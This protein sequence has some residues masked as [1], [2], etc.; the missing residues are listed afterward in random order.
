MKTVF[1]LGAGA[2]RAAGGPL[3][4][5][6]LD[7]AQDLLRFQTPGITK[8]QK[9]FDDVFKAIAELQ[10]VHSKAYLDLNNIEIVFGAIEMG[11]LLKQLGDRDEDSIKALRD[12]LITL[13]YKTLEFSI[14]FPAPNGLLNPPK[15]YD[16]FMS[17]LKRIKEDHPSPDPHCF[18]FITFNYD[19]CLD[20]TLYRYYSSFN[21]CLNPDQYSTDI[22]LLKLHG[23]INWGLSADDRIVPFK[24]NDFHFPFSKGGDGYMNCDLGSRLHEMAVDGK[25]LKGPPVIVP[26]TWNK[27]SYHGQLSNVWSRAAQE[28]STAEN[29]FIIG[30][31]L[32]ETDSFFRY[33]Y[34]LGSESPTRIR[35]F[36]V[37]NK[38]DSGQ[39]EGRFRQLIGR[40]IETRF[41]YIGKTFEE[42]IGQIKDILMNP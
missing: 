16:G 6:F 30:Y 3:M 39:V 10:G 25:P 31:S 24:I 21:Y 9:E 42:S 1:L 19:L 17:T 26:P 35:N 40:G 13:I 38:D 29:I 7:R 27:N 18:C 34:A 23:S 8:A 2:S 33:L 5:D 32:P 37:I 22:P 12:S 41:H 11:L 14:Q 28:L 36:I 4:S 20:Y 15:P